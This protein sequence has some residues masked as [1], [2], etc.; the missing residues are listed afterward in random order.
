MAAA[1]V[2][3]EL[4]RRPAKIDA[5][6]QANLSEAN[7][8]LD[9]THSRASPT[10][11]INETLFDTFNC[12]SRD[13]IDLL[14]F[15]SRRFRQLVDDCLASVCL[16]PLLEASLKG[17]RRKN[18]DSFEVTIQRRSV[19]SSAGETEERDGY[20][21]WA[22]DEWD[23][24]EPPKHSNTEDVELIRE[25]FTNQIDA[26]DFLLLRLRCCYVGE[27]YFEMM[28]VTYDI[29]RRIAEKGSCTVL[30]DLSVFNVNSSPESLKG[31]LTECF[32]EVREVYLDDEY[33]GMYPP[34]QSDELVRAC[35]AK[36]VYKMELNCYAP[37]RA[38]RYALSDDGILDFSFGHANDKPKEFKVYH[39]ALSPQFFKRLVEANL[40]SKL[41]SRIRIRIWTVDNPNLDMSDYERHMKQYG[42]TQV[43]DFPGKVRFQIRLHPVLNRHPQWKLDFRRCKEPTDGTRFFF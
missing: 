22:D 10:A 16:R 38:D 43:F 42:A 6:V 5:S 23:D 31:L 13:D 21:S 40:N 11:L 7:T 37:K 12:L 20:D 39:V 32:A 2:F 34:H 27:L 3:S 1:L 15:T 19:G 35:V 25:T 28:P 36:S 29:C 30:Q 14:R 41:T 8:S 24:W 33:G 18:P 4:F 9:S 17:N 26:L